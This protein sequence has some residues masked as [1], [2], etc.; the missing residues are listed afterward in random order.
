MMHLSQAAARLSRPRGAESV[1]DEGP[2]RVA[3]FPDSFHEV[4]GVA[5]TSRHFEAFARR[6][7]LPFLCVRAGTRPEP[8]Q[9]TGT[10]TTLELPRG[11]FSFALDKDL[12]FDV[13]FL[14]HV[15][16]IRRV[17]RDFRPDVIH[18]TGPSEVGMLGAWLAHRLHIPL[19][20]SWHTNVHEY[21]AMR[22]DWLLDRLPRGRRKGVADAIEGTTLR[23]TAI[24]YRK[25]RVL[26]APN[27][28]L[29]SLLEKVT[30][31]TCL[32]MPRGVDA[33]LFSPAHRTRTG[34]GEF[35][36]G[37]VGRLS[38]EKNIQLLARV[39]REL[40][41]RGVGNFRMLVS[42]RA[43]KKA[44]C[45]SGCPGQ[46]LPACCAVRRSP[47]PMPTWTC[48]YFHRTPI[49]LAMWCWR[50]WLQACPRW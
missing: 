18:I 22:S 12:S 39:H 9:T 1:R 16:S 14:R 31:R 36:L 3:Y 27:V 47:K 42:G 50:R 4:N 5:H 49:P 33:E 24:F 45:V 32:L 15:P 13:N 10:V 26:F 43:R 35:V 2:L 40:L 20:A 34:E 48:S 29:C 7:G 11:F 46:R 8:L 38:V 37:F 41:V 17:L 23:A 6:R 19:V 30:S 28:E 21:L 25:A 44:G